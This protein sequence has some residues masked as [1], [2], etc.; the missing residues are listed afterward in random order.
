MC[1]SLV[2]PLFNGSGLNDSGSMAAV[3]T[4]Q[5]SSARDDLVWLGMSRL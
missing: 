1:S 3:A 4:Q 2:Q 5:L